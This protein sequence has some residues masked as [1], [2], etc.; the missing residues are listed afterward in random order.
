[1]ENPIH[2]CRVCTDSDEG[3]KFVPVYE[4]S[5]KVAMEIFLITG[6]KI[7]QLNKMPALI[8]GN[9]VKELS[10][11]M[12][13]RNKCRA[14]DEFFRRSHFEEEKIIWGSEQDVGVNLACESQSN[15]NFRVKQESSFDGQRIKDEPYDDF[16]VDLFENIDTILEENISEESNTLAGILKKAKHEEA[17]YSDS[18]ES[19]TEYEARKKRKLRIAMKRSAAEFRDFDLW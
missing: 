5:N 16:R 12:D 15:D 11:A 4:K 6:V 2:M 13:F 14:T 17:S 19:E 3:G 9:C 7:L 1:M 8:C 18:S 10:A